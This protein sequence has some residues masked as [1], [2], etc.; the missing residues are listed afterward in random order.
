MSGYYLDLFDEKN[1][2]STTYGSW[3]TNTFN[4]RT[5]DPISDSG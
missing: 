2:Q 4:L 5:T 3:H 1:P